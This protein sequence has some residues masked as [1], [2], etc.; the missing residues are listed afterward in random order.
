MFDISLRDLPPTIHVQT[1]GKIIGI[2]RT[3][4]YKAARSGVLPGCFRVGNRWKVATSVLLAHL[5]IS[6]Q[7]ERPPGRDQG[8]SDAPSGAAWEQPS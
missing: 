1:A 2:G 3:S 4:S 8:A 5:G 7:T 6:F